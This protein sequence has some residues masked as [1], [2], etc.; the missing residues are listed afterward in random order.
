MT[1]VV[2][3]DL[4]GVEN[5]CDFWGKGGKGGWSK[6]KSDGITRE[7]AISHQDMRNKG[8]VVRYPCHVVFFHF[9]DLTSGEF[10]KIIQF[11][12]VIFTL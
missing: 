7:L 2:G 11:D 3:R 5:P 8:A 1:L 9:K 10:C 4:L 12:N 6:K